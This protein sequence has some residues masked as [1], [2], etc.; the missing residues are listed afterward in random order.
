MHEVL[1][2]VAELHTRWRM[3]AIPPIGVVARLRI[4][5]PSLSALQ[6]T[7]SATTPSTPETG[8]RGQPA[9]DRPSRSPPGPPSR[10]YRLE[11]RHWISHGLERQQIPIDLSQE[12]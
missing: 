9:S 12:R 11:L 2:G 8:P 5:G 1:A 6:R 7:T 4:Q 10:H 3:A